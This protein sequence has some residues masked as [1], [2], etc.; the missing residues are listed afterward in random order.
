MQKQIGQ[1]IKTWIQPGE[2]VF[3]KVAERDGRPV[4]SAGAEKRLGCYLL[5]V[6]QALDVVVVDD[7]HLVVHG[8]KRALEG[9]DVGDETEKN[10]GKNNPPAGVEGLPETLGNSAEF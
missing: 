3:Q 4:I 9:E 6:P 7:L 2:V 8:L 10:E 5:E 1:I